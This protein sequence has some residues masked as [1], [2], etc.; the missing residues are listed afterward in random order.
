[1]MSDNSIG[2]LFEF[3]D[4]FRRF[5]ILVLMAM[6]WYSLHRCFDLI[7]DNSQVIVDGYQWGA[8][9]G[10]LQAILALVLGKAMA[11]DKGKKNE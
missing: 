2:A 11:A 4:V 1:M 7:E 9:L 6:S 3:H 5:V 10:A 8:V